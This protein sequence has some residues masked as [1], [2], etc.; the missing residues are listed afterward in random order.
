MMLLA[1]EMAPPFLV[2]GAALLVAAAAI[3]YVC[4][5]L[6]LVPIVGF[7]IAGVVIG[8]NGL[9]LVRD[10]ETTSAVADVGVILLLFTI[11]IEFSLS[12]LREM[13]RQVL[14]GGSAQMAFVPFPMWQKADSFA[15]L[16]RLWSVFRYQF[17]K[18]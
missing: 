10:R 13:Q 11:G 2:Q 4:A 12:R 7:L 9:N 14:A 1:T 18:P 5:R 15:P 16:I 8:P 3:A 6:G 17:I